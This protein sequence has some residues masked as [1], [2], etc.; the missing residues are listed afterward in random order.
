MKVAAVEA[1]AALARVEASDVVATAYGGAAPVFG[2]DYIIPK[3]FDPR[4]ILH[5]APAVARAAMECGVAR[6]PI[7]DF[8]AYENE[9][10]SFVFRSGQLMRPVFDAARQSPRRVVYA[11]GEEDRVLRAVQTVVDEGLAQPILIGRR[12]VIEARSARWACAWISPTACACSTRRRTTT[13]SRRCCPTISAW[14]DAAA[15]SRNAAAA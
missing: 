13:S 9:L 8:D 4:L 6:R 7:T 5:I 15:C 3:P 1:I 10:E 12:E 14:W 2:P 11:E